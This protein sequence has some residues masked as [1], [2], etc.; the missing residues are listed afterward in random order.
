MRKLFM[1][2]LCASLLFQHMSTIH[3]EEAEME[4]T[5]NQTESI[6]V[7]GITVSPSSL[8][9]LSGETAQLS[10]VISPSDADNQNVTWRS[11][12][13]SVV[14][15]DQNGFV[16]AA[17]AGN[18]TVIAMSEDGGYFDACSVN[19]TAKAESFS[20]E[21][22][23]VWLKPGESKQIE[24]TLYPEGSVGTV[25]WEVNWGN[26]IAT[27]DPDGTVHASYDTGIAYWYGKLDG[28]YLHQYVIFVANEPSSISL[29]DQQI[30]MGVDTYRTCYLN[31]NE[32]SAS[33]CR[34]HITSS[35]PDIVEITSEEW[36]GW[37]SFEVHAKAAG[38]ATITVTADNGVS[39]SATVEVLEGKFADSIRPKEETVWLKPGEEKQ[40]E[41]ILEPEDAEDVVEWK[42]SYDHNIQCI[43]LKE[44]GIVHADNVYADAYVDAYIYNGSHAHYQIYVA[45]D[46]DS[47]TA[48][49]QKIIMSKGS[50]RQIYL[51]TQPNN[52]YNCRK[53]VV[54]SDPDTVSVDR[55]WTASNFSVHANEA[56]T[57][58]ISVTADNG[59]STEIEVEVVD[60]LFADSITAVEDEVWLK[61]GESKQLEYILD[62]ADAQ[63]PVEWSSSGY[64]PNGH[65]V[66]LNENGKVTA[67]KIGTEYIT[68]RILNGNSVEYRVHVS[69][70]P[71]SFGIE[72]KSLIM[73]PGTSESIYISISPDSASRCR[74]RVVSDHPEIVSVEREYTGDQY[75]Y[76]SSHQ[77]GKAVISI[78]ADNGVSA[79]VEVE[80]IEGIAESISAAGSS[81]PPGSGENE[82]WLNAGESMQLEYVLS[83]STAQETPLFTSSNDEIVS[84]DK[85]GMITA[86][87]MQGRAQISAVIRNGRSVSWQVRI[88]EQPSK[89]YFEK[90]EYQM[91]PGE[92]ASANVLFEPRFILGSHLE[93]SSSDPLV[94]SFGS[95]DEHGSY[96]SPSTFKAHKPGK[97]I[98]TA[99]ADNGVSAQAEVTVMDGYADTIRT[100]QSQIFMYLGETL[101][102]PYRLSSY[103]G[104]TSNEKITWE[105]VSGSDTVSVDQNGK[106]T[107]KAYGKAIVCGALSSLYRN[108]PDAVID[109]WSYTPDVVRFEV[110]VAKQPESLH[111]PRD[112]YEI[113]AGQSLRLYA[114]SD[115][116][117]S[118]NAEKEY[119][120]SDPSIVSMNFYG[121]EVS[122]TG[123]KPGTATVTAKS[124][125]GVSASVVITVKDG[126][127]ISNTAQSRGFNWLQ[128]CMY[129]GEVFDLRQ[130]NWGGV[131]FDP[132][133]RWVSKDENV[134]TVEDGIITAVSQG[135][136][137]IEQVDPEGIVRT[138]W[139]V[140]VNN[141]QSIHFIQ[142]EYWFPVNTYLNYDELLYAEPNDQMFDVSMVSSDE[143]I[144]HIAEEGT[145]HYGYTIKTGTVVVNAETGNGL[146]AQCIVHVGKR[147]AASQLELLEK[148]PLTVHTGY[149]RKVELQV[150]PAYANPFGYTLESSD[151][152]VV[153]IISRD[154]NDSYYGDLSAWTRPFILGVK[155]GTATVTARLKENPDV[156]VAFDVTVED[157]IPE[158]GEY[159]QVMYRLDDV[160]N[161]AEY[162]G[163]SDEYTCYA[164]ERYIILGQG[165]ET[166]RGY[167]ENGLHG[168]MLSRKIS[169]PVIL[170]NNN[171]CIIESRD[172][173][174]AA[175]GPT[176]FYYHNEEF[177]F[178]AAHP[179]NAVVKVSEEKTVRIKVIDRDSAVSVYGNSLNLEGRIGVNYYLDIPENEAES[180]D[181][182]ISVNGNDTVIHAKDAPVRTVSGKP[183]RLV[184]VFVSAKE[185]RDTIVLRVFDSNGLPRTL[186]DTEGKDVTETGYI[187][188]VASY[189]E[190]AQASSNE[191]LKKLTN[192]MNTYGKYAQIYFNYHTNQFT[193]TE[194]VSAVT[195]DTVK[196]YRALT[197]GSVEGLNYLGGS[198][199]LDSDTSVR[200][201]FTLDQGRNIKEF[202]FR[203]NGEDAEALSGGNG[204]YYIALNNIAA[205]DLHKSISF[206]AEKDDEVIMVNYYPLSYAYSAL[207]SDKTGDAIRNTCRAL[208]LYNQQAIEYFN[209]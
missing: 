142:D 169:H 66:E 47:I 36:N 104:N 64:G 125:N 76:L 111:F 91:I 166:E 132:S 140:Y 171:N 54:S 79:S 203:V 135:T 149:L 98:I 127:G 208:Y 16:T 184:S 183:M 113:Y 124:A 43:T 74:K 117:E 33:Y 170:E 2:I 44:G 137:V 87:Y 114:V 39:T 173:T 123:I 144:L 177:C 94:V 31:V 69:E 22:Y 130:S 19:V 181:I 199:E 136:A 62:P 107:A 46:P 196:K 1:G 116:A 8:E 121:R 193:E 176:A 50:E 145:A 191:K 61:L 119:I 151:P 179:G 206:T 164:G 75:I 182:S 41:Y 93:Y 13:T 112:Q 152:E 9:L 128:P 141:A 167:Q 96:T 65:A 14:S 70:E 159:L 99:T 97:A 201:Y 5:G 155:A 6:P 49:K 161:K 24:Y 80:V 109:E 106:I 35:N 148:E 73:A 209:N 88:N 134:A 84:V 195:A 126:S 3:A 67:K 15:V 139:F 21:S 25:E 105:V 156:S 38:T 27:I 154:V 60:G 83:P 160:R 189:F 95:Y 68:A 29:E 34:K 115:S 143:E 178:L 4:N 129:P 53:H 108:S 158:D 204:R 85:N 42:L 197:A 23:Y 187:Y 71:T 165:L 172:D 86:E 146:K 174:G 207:S 55:E 192:A 205:Q 147:A 185:M 180:T 100:D 120:S 110:F 52:A 175:S 20:S 138:I 32:R 51:D 194:D 102:L 18:A 122:V 101:S 163:S 59:I 10:A 82:V 186:F 28:S 63:D 40:L 188:S 198:L 162:I 57:S 90:N 72:K 37:Q 11:S 12:N 118:E 81:G 48:S 26:D 7:S 168:G 153:K 190:K 56:G 45:A 77:A 58:R 131:E 89:M 200:V 103:S 157:G 133:F 202:T 30:K 92:S 78:T 150:L 17:G